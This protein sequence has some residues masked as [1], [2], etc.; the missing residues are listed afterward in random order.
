MNVEAVLSRFSNVQ[1]QGPGQYSASCPVP[2]HGRGRGDKNPSL[3]ISKGAG[4]ETLIN[5]LSGCSTQAV[6]AA[7]GLEMSDLFP[8][9]SKRRGT[10]G[11]KTD[12]DSKKKKSLS[13]IKD[14]WKILLASEKERMRKQAAKFLQKKRAISQATVSDAMSGSGIHRKVVGALTFPD[15]EALNQFYGGKDAPDPLSLGFLFTNLPGDK[16]LAI[17]YVSATGLPLRLDG[18]KKLFAIGSRAGEGFFIVGKPIREARE[19]VLVEAC[20]SALAAV[21]LRPNAC[22]IAL[23]SA[24]STA[25]LKNFRS[26]LQRKKNQQEPARKIILAF[27]HDTAGKDATARAMRILYYGR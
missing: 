25:K 18:K 17:E 12:P 9:H 22:A 8:S 10:R 7:I 21:D 19:I 11:R 20:V 24:G 6:V 13:A 5:C 16:A 26:F 23:G 4:G 27:D 15:T 3:Q 14:E 1:K 2:G